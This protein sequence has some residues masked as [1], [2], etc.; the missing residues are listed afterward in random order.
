MIESLY[1]NFLESGKVST[2]TRQIT[3]G[4]IFFALKGPNFNANLLA[5]EA[6]DKGASF[7]VIDEEKYK[8]DD[9]YILVD[10]VLKT[11]QQLAHH[12][13]KQLSIPIIGLTG[14]NG[15]TTTKELIDAVLSRKYKT[16]ATKGNLNNHIGV[17]LTLLSITEDHE[18]AIVEMGA[19]HQK[20]I[21]ALSAI[22]DPTH[23]LITNIGKAHLEGFGGIEGVKKGKSE[24]YKHLQANGGTVFINSNNPI[25]MSMESWFEQPIFY[26]NSGDYYHCSLVEA[27][28][29]LKI[30]T[31]TSEIIA[32]RLVGG[33][34]FENIATALCIGKFF[35][36]PAREAANA[37]ETY[38]PQ[39]NRSQLI[40]KGATTIIMDAYNA[41]PN[42][43]EGALENLKSV[44]GPKWVVLGDMKELGD[45]SYKEHVALGQR[46][47]GMD[48]EA[49]FLLGPEMRAAF[50]SCP[51]AQY[52]EDK[53]RLKEA[54]KSVNSEGKTVLLKGSR[55][56][57]LE[58]VIDAL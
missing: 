21:E 27:S 55:S 56:M 2:D 34:N 51:N 40:K 39:N 20:E 31:E 41:N 5:D 25:L 18:I 15:K 48:L 22:V 30:R 16:Q 43:M 47:H 19:N 50:D 23:G 32:T 37:I 29:V 1:Q 28:P 11:L 17:P 26:P 36:V 6:L 13:R 33:Y 46:L 35:K 4:A 54:L 9:R 58:E 53:S 52:F 8:K 10:N 45:D 42:S 57:G 7:V 44:A 3:S 24:L 38:D 12:H 49:I 14:S